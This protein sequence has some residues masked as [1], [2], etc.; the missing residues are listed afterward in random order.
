MGIDA[1]T[2]IDGGGELR[3][4]DRRLGGIGG[5]PVGTA[6]DL[7]AADAAAGEQDAVALGPMLAPG[8]AAGDARR[9]AELRGHDNPSRLG[10]QACSFE[11]VPPD[12]RPNCYAPNNQSPSAAVGGIA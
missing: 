3:G 10:W 5:A 12:R 6:E 4:G 7:P 11:V 9:A 2:V 8:V 1:E